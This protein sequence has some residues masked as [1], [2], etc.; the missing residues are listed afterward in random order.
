[1]LGDGLAVDDQKSAF[2]QRDHRRLDTAIEKPPTGPL[3]RLP[4]TGTNSGE[5]LGLGFV[6]HHD[7]NSAPR[8]GG[9]RLGGSR[10]HDQLQTEDAAGLDH[11]TDHRQRNLQLDQHHRHL[12]GEVAQAPLDG[13]RP[14][15]VVG[16]RHDRDVVLPG[17]GVDPDVRDTG[18]PVDHLHRGGVD[19][20]GGQRVEGQ[21]PEEVVADRTHHEGPGTGACR[22]Q[23]LV[24]PFPA[25]HHREGLADHRLA[26]S[27]QRM[28]EDGQIRADTADHSHSACHAGELIFA[29]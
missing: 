8:V 29:A 15:P 4:I 5:H 21:C 16:V 28:G 3:G 14:Q 23:G 13:V 26:R 25:E 10:I 22:R 19:A 6:G 17:G 11:P 9:Q 2:G 27:R 12:P 18:V 7:R 1:M 20:F 24:R